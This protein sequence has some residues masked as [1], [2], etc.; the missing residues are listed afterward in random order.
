VGEAHRRYTDFS[1]GQDG[2]YFEGISFFAADGTRIDN[3]PDHHS[4]NLTAKHQ[5]TASR[6]KPAIR[7]FKNIRSK[8]IERG[9]LLKGEAPSYY[10]EGLLYNVPNELFAGTLN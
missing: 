10:I 6:Y 8:L 7:I 2:S 9:L 3:F 4:Q 1:G 5:A